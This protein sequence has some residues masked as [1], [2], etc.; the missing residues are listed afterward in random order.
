MPM[1]AA[2]SPPKVMARLLRRELQPT[3]A[4]ARPALLLPAQSTGTEAAPL[5]SVRALA[6]ML[7]DDVREGTIVLADPD[8]VAFCWQAGKAA[9]VT[10]AADGKVDAWHGLPVTV[11][12]V[13]RAVTDGVFECELPDSHFASF[14]GATV[15]MGRSVWL[16][17]SGVNILL[18]ERNTPPLDLA[19]LRHIGIGAGVA[20]HDRRQI[21]GCLSRCLYADCGRCDQDGHSWLMQR[22]SVRLSLSTLE[23]PRLSAGLTG[24]PILPHKPPE[25]PSR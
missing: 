5:S 20:E 2:S 15:H 8:A 4:I 22:Q 25:R 23:A 10:H 24:A 21:R 16:R 11:T 12:G 6:A 14:Y 19:Q 9:Q 3:A 17:V 18:S 1:R 13:V 7:A